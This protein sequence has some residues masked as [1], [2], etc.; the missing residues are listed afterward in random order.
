MT[1]WYVNDELRRI[2]HE[3]EESLQSVLR[4]RREWQALSRPTHR[5]VLAWLGDRLIGLG[6]RLQS[7]SMPSPQQALPE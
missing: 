1:D 4:W 6:E 5:P 2:A 7:W 3:Q